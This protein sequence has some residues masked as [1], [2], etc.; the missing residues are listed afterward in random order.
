MSESAQ[1][2]M[3]FID[4]LHNVFLMRRGYG[5]YAYI[6][7]S[8]ALALFDKYKNSNESADFFIDQFVRS[9]LKNT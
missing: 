5:A 9:A 2:R 4:Q 7:T 8:D 6:S 1:N 3:N